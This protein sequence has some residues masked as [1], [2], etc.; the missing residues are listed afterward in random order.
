[1]ANS[2]V[3][4]VV[5]A[6]GGRDD[7]LAAHFG[8]AAKALAPFKG[9]PLAAYVLEALQRS[10]V[11]SETVFVGLESSFLNQFT[12]HRVAAGE[13]LVE[14]LTHGVEAALQLLQSEQR[15][16]VVSADLPWLSAEAVDGVVQAVPEAAFVYPIIPQRAAERQFPGQK[17]TYVKLKEGR[18]TGGNLMLLTPEITASLLP[19][20][21]RVYRAR[22]NPLALAGIVGPSTLLKL[23]TRRLGLVE[24]EQRVSKLIGGSARALISEYACIGA[25]VD[26]PEQ[27]E[28]IEDSRLKIED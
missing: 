1:M 6:G 16:L 11:V 10:R 2:Q 9:K 28:L 4:A 13:N 21:E 7:P 20:V 23:V 3:V 25:D 24:L 19:F 18:F 8:V 5:L 27:L 22:K 26:R 12:C 15:L 14:S 17:R